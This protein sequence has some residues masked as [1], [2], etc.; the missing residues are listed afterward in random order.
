MRRPSFSCLLNPT[1]RLGARVNNRL[2][3]WIEVG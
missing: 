3:G 2:A 1:V